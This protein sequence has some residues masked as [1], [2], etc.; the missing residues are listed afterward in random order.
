MKNAFAVSSH[1]PALHAHVDSRDSGRSA[2]DPEGDPHGGLRAHGRNDRGNGP[3]PRT[4]VP[5]VKNVIPRV[6][7]SGGHRRGGGADHGIDRCR[8]ATIRLAHER[9]LGVGIL[10]TSRS[11]GTRTGRRTLGFSCGRNLHG[12]LAWL[13]VVRPDEGPAA[14]ADA[15]AARRAADLRLG[16][17]P[18]LP[19][20][21][22][23]ATGASPRGG[24]RRRPGG[25]SSRA[26]AARGTS[27]GRAQRE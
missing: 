12:M 26:T 21:A 17:Q 22:R 24:K 13:G 10:V 7:R 8:S 18:R 6:G 14:A 9:G 1:A 23:C 16:V 15:H 3:G 11:S 2:R 20:M 19:A 27:R 4:M 5:V 25:A